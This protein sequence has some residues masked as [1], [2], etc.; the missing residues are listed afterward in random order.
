MLIRLVAVLI[1]S[2]VPSFAQAQTEGIYHSLL[3]VVGCERQAIIER[4]EGYRAFFRNYSEALFDQQDNQC[5]ILFSLNM[6]GYIR[7]AIIQGKQDQYDAFFNALVDEFEATVLEEQASGLVCAETGAIEETDAERIPRCRSDRLVEI[8]DI[9]NRVWYEFFFRQQAQG[10]AF[11][12]SLVILGG[13]GAAYVVVSIFLRSLRTKFTKLFKHIKKVLRRPK[14]VTVSTRAGAAGTAVTANGEDGA[15]IERSIT[16]YPS[17]LEYFRRGRGL[18]EKVRDKLIG[19]LRNGG[20]SIAN[21]FYSFTMLFSGEDELPFD[22]G[23]LLGYQI[24]SGAE[25]TRDLILEFAMAVAPYVLGEKAAEKLLGDRLKNDELPEPPPNA[26]RDTL[27]RHRFVRYGR[28]AGRFAVIFVSGI[29]AA[30]ATSQTVTQE[31]QRR[32]FE[33]KI[34]NAFAEI[35]RLKS[36]IREIGDASDSRVYKLNQ[37]LVDLVTV[38]LVPM[39]VGGRMLALDKVKKSHE[40]SMMCSVLS[41]HYHARDLETDVDGANVARPTEFEDKAK[42]VF[43][44]SQMTGYFDQGWQ[45]LVQTSAFVGGFNKPEYYILK[46]PIYDL[47]E[48]VMSYREYTRYAGD[49]RRRHYSAVS[50]YNDHAKS[51]ARVKRDYEAAPENLP[52]NVSAGQWLSFFRAQDHFNSVKTELDDEGLGVRCLP[53]FMDRLT[54]FDKFFNNDNYRSHVPCSVNHPSVERDYCVAN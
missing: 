22:N 12:S 24:S 14:T 21:F 1:L 4:A 43:D 33:T 44:S 17:P 38:Q 45:L 32:Q 54:H 30:V 11:K 35:E 19:I 41:D 36:R 13:A 6:T 20:M 53:L 50:G 5:D 49:L 37:E 42:K 7:H 26:C 18:Q 29:A 51:L 10:D 3:P 9:A 2:L 23:A 47:M 46:A 15:E 40:S 28:F 31:I 48:Q 8:S 27:K 34:G 52:A 25:D 39:L 16:D